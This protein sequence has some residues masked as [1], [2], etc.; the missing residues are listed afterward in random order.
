MDIYL[1]NIPK[2]TRPAEIKRLVKESFRGHIFERIY[3]RMLSLGRF[4]QG[5][6]IN[7]KNRRSREGGRYGRIHFHS[8]L[9][10]EFALE[11]LDGSEI[12]GEGISVRPFVLRDSNNDRRHRDRPWDG[13]DRR[14]KERRRH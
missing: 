13:K 2:G 12:R 9:M 10:G 11:I 5:M 14:R 1:G 8:R 6:A 4:E 7:I 3:E